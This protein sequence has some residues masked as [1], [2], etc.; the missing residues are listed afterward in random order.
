MYEDI[1]TGLKQAVTEHKLVAHSFVSADQICQFL[2]GR[3]AGNKTH[4]I[5][6]ISLTRRLRWFLYTSHQRYNIIY[7]S[8]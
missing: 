3:V 8:I 6:R 4:N 1:A 7:T 5:T 2:A